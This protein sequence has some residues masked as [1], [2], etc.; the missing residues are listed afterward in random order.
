MQSDPIGLRGGIN[1]FGY[2]GANPV[3]RTDEQGLVSGCVLVGVLIVCKDSTPVGPVDPYVPPVPPTPKPASPSTV[4][5]GSHLCAMSPLACAVN[6][7]SNA[8]TGLIRNFCKSE[9]EGPS[10]DECK[11]RAA[12]CRQACS[13]SY[14]GTPAG[15]DGWN[16]QKCYNLCMGDCL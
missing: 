13:D 16:W 11:E 7:A 4:G 15:N 3:S 8:A 12:D 10:P 9:R 1:T 5:T 14:L 2:V 6:Y